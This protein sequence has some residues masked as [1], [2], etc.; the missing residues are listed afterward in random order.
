MA[1]SERRASQRKTFTHHG[2]PHVIPRQRARTDRPTEPEALRLRFPGRRVEGRHDGAALMAEKCPELL[3][4][5]RLQE[6]RSPIFGKPHVHD[7]ETAHSGSVDLSANF[8]P[9]EYSARVPRVFALC[10][11]SPRSASWLVS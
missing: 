1:R 11:P 6:R 3:T 9:S 2:G 4:G 8:R 10:S 5:I 7:D